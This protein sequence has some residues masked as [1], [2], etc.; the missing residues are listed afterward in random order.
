MLTTLPLPTIANA[1][2]D[3]DA[4]AVAVENVAN[5]ARQGFC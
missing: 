3:A 1:A 2:E 4:N 5:A